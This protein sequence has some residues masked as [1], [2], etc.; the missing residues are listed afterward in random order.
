M[1]NEQGRFT[2]TTIIATIGETVGLG[3]VVYSKELP[4]DGNLPPEL[5]GKG[6]WFKAS[7]DYIYNSDAEGPKYA[8]MNQLGVVVEA[9]TYSTISSTQ[10]GTK[11][12]ILL[13]GYY[14][15]GVMG[16]GGYSTGEGLSGGSIYLMPQNGTGVVSN[17]DGSLGCVSYYTPAYH[18]AKEGVVRVLGY[19][20]DIVSPHVIRFQPDNSWELYQNLDRIFG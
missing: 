7:S 16:F 2:G 9:A 1:A 15:P 11:T 8:G 12:T 17:P 19:Y 6:I 10:S 5:I 13:D 3:Q 14:S 20:W 18:G 4:T